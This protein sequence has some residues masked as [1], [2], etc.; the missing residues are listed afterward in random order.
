ML[1]DIKDYFLAILM[2]ELEYM[3]VKYCYLPPDM[4]WKYN[5]DTLVSKDDYIHIRIQKGMPRLK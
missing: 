4:Y 1:A 5:L 3:R 2:K